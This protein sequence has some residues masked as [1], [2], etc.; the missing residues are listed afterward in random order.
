M[1]E[2][3]ICSSHM[4]WSL[5]QW[6]MTSDWTSSLHQW[7]WYRVT[8]ISEYL[9]PTTLRVQTL[10]VCPN[11]EC[12]IQWVWYSLADNCELLFFSTSFKGSNF[13][14]MICFHI[15]RMSSEIAV[16]TVL[17]ETTKFPRQHLLDYA[18]ASGSWMEDHCGK[19]HQEGILLRYGALCL[20]PFLYEMI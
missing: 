1:T 18:L 4:C 12:R 2:D 3:P 17:V 11:D 8:L 9:F 20:L 7:I 14:G 13:Y 6:H 15:Y 5:C 16:S 10:K 19:F